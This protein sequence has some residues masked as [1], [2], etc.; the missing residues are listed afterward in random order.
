MDVNACSEPEYVGDLLN[1]VNPADPFALLKAALLVR[2]VVPAD[3]DP[4]LPVQRLMR[5]FGRGLWLRTSTTIPRGSGLG[6]SSI[7]AGAVLEA[8]RSLLDLG[9]DG[10]GPRSEDT[11]PGA[12]AV[13]QPGNRQSSEVNQ[14]LGDLFDE[15]L[16]LEQLLTTG[17]GWQDQVGG[18]TG[19]VKL[20]TT[21]PG[22]P[23][24]IN[25]QPVRIPHTVQIE[26]AERLLLVYTGQQRLAKNLLQAIVG[27][28]MGRDTDMA[29]MLGEIARLA[30]AMRDALTAGDLDGLGWLLAEHWSINKRMDPGCSNPFIDNLFE[31]MRPFLCGGKLAGAGGGGFALVLA[32]DSQ[33]AHDLQHDLALRYRGTPIGVWACSIPDQGMRSEI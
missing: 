26:L 17:G 32:K 24:R 4:T 9:E 12:E 33:A 21:E 19:G 18:L 28:W 30:V 1:Y 25:L 11:R 23:Q 20:I 14:K 6:T 15:V 27:R 7:M 8:L 10:G 29:W 16:W 3:A 5:D 13:G 2:G 31:T 22:L